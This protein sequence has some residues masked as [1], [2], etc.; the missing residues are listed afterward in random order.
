MLFSNLL[1]LSTRAT[2]IVN[3]FYI[4]VSHAA[5]CFTLSLSIPPFPSTP[6]PYVRLVFHEL[7]E[8]SNSR[9]T[10][11]DKTDFFGRLLYPLSL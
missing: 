11:E 2:S 3:I 7:T 10:K 8:E 1:L 5:R 4:P 6:L 9:L